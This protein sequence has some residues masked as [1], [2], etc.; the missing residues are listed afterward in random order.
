M[1]EV[2]DAGDDVTRSFV[3]RFPVYTLYFSRFLVYFAI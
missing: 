3:A 2:S 1:V